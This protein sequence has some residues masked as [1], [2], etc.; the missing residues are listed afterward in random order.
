M[1]VH[2]YIYTPY[3]L[4]ELFTPLH[5]E[6]LLLGVYRVPRT[7]AIGRALW[8]EVQVYF[9][10][11]RACGSV[12]VARSRWP[13][14][15]VSQ[16]PSP[17]PCPVPRSR[18]HVCPAGLVLV[19]V[20]RSRSRSRCPPRPFTADSILSGPG[21]RVS[22]PVKRITY[23]VWPSPWMRNLFQEYGCSPNHW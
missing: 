4:Y 12:P 3:Y 10:L 5:R 19:A 8:G 17:A 21:G 15:P 23:A 14:G 13:G 7:S 20:A 2:I 22:V 18:S 1:H 9:C 11:V 6:P 16:W